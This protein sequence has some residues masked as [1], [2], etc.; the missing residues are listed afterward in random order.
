MQTAVSIVALVLSALSIGWQAATF[1]LTGGRVKVELRVG[2]FH[3]SGSGM[4]H[5]AV[6]DAASAWSGHEAA[7]GYTRP[8]LVVQVRNVGRLPVTVTEWSVVAQPGGASFRPVAGSIGPNLPY[9]MEPG[10]SETWAVDAGEVLN[11]AKVSAATSKVAGGVTRIHGRVG[12]GD[13]RIVTTTEALP[14]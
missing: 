5:A 4:I 6:K 3:A 9:R 2:A 11:L 1:V 8:V 12:L 13:G 7:Q 14:V 10:T